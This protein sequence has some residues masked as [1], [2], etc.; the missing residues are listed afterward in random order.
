MAAAVTEGTMLIVS[1]A[2]T[3]KLGK[4]TVGVRLT[5]AEVVMIDK[6]P[7]NDD[8]VRVYSPVLTVAEGVMVGFGTID[9]NEGPFQL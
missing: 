7:F 9:V 2:H 3:E 5:L 4:L 1:P 8:T 6:Q